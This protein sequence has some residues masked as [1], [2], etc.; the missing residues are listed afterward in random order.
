[1]QYISAN[2]AAKKWG[3]TI[4]RI[5]QLCS[6]NRIPGV[7][8]MGRSWMIPA[9]TPKPDDPRRA[10]RTGGVFLPYAPLMS[11]VAFLPQDAESAAEFLPDDEQRAQFAGELAY[12]KGDFK[13]AKKCFSLGAINSPTRICALIIAS[14]AAVCDDDYDIFS[15]AINEFNAIKHRFKSNEDAVSLSELGRC[16]VSISM[17]DAH[18]IPEWLIAGDFSELPPASKPL[19]LYL[20]AKYLHRAGLY[21]RMLGVTQAALALRNTEVY[22]VTDI[23]TEIMH[24]MA[25]VDTGD[26][27]SAKESMRHAMDIA[28]PGGLIT[29]IAEHVGMLGGVVEECLKDEKYAP[30]RAQVIDQFN[31]TCI[32]WRNV[33]KMAVRDNVSLVLSLDEYRAASFSRSGLSVARIADRMGIQ[34]AAAT[35][36]L[37]NAFTKLGIHKKSEL[38]RYIM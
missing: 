15:Q 12:L 18:N 38:K 26:I 8:K 23:Y 31:A 25:C 9:N 1:M 37:R 3:I 27:E 5:Q 17:F 6:G 33:Y 11:N 29:P 36:L 7:T 35:K 24:A 30:W 16:V 13:E 32:A 19:A 4:R 34:S 20:Y 2:E 22:S 10:R 14:V 28:L 21:E